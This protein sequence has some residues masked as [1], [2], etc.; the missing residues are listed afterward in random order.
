MFKYVKNLNGSHGTPEVIEIPVDI[1]ES[2]PEGTLCS[3][4]DEYIDFCDG[5]RLGRTYVTIENKA[6][7]DG[8]TRL[9]VIKALPGMVFEVPIADVGNIS[10]VGTGRLISSQA[11]DESRHTMV[12]PN[13]GSYIEV[14]STDNYLTTGKILV[15]FI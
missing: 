10:E 2:I 1:A 15:T 8:K 12:C 5:G 3:F 7:G 14:V 4:L 13:N 6:S 9:K 11:N